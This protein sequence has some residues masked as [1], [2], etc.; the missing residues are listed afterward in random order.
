[1][2]KKEIFKILASLALG[3][4]IIYASARLGRYVNNLADLMYGNSVRDSIQ[5]CLELSYEEKTD[6]DNYG[7]TK[8]VLN[9]EIYNFCK[10]QKGL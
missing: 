8:R 4:C 9:E 10:S 1:M 7:Q 6:E 5:G 2:M 3:F